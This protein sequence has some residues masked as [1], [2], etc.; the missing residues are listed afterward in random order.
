MPGSSETEFVESGHRSLSIVTGLELRRW[1]VATSYPSFAIRCPRA[2]KTLCGRLEIVDRGDDHALIRRCG[3]PSPPP[4][5]SPNDDRA[6]ASN[7]HAWS[8]DRGTIELNRRAGRSC[9]SSGVRACSA[10]G[11]ELHA[12][13]DDAGTAETPLIQWQWWRRRESNPNHVIC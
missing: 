3:V 11:A 4:P 5:L 13:L 10:A 12:T 8:A 6:T 9:P 1:D 2:L 7:A